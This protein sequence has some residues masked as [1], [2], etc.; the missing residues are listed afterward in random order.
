MKI[1]KIIGV[2]AGVITLLCAVSAF[3]FM[4]E[5]KEIKNITIN[6]VAPEELSDG[7]YYGESGFLFRSNKLAV[8][9]KNHEI[10]QIDILRDAMIPV[11]ELRKEVYTEL[12]KEV[13]EKQTTKIDTVSGA[14]ATTK[15]YLKSIDNALNKGEKQEGD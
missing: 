7:K 5:L 10:S 8:T 12:F 11:E 1:L 15:Q 3:A 9:I 2:S 13:I 14:T 4:M 6:D